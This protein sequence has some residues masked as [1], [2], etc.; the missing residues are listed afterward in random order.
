M[1]AFDHALQLGADM[2]GS[3]SHHRR[4]GGG[5]P[6][7][8]DG[9]PHHRRIGS[10]LRHDPGAGPG[11][12]RRTQLRP[13]REHSQRRRALR[14]SAPRRAYRRAQ[15]AA[16]GEAR[17]LPDSDAREVLR[18][19]PT[20]PTNIEIKGTADADVA[21]LTR[22][23]EALAE[24]LNRID[25]SEGII[26][27]SFNDAAIDHFRRRAPQIDLAPGIAGVA[28]FKPASVPPDLV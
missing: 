7:R 5:R 4:R 14:V 1:Y 17:R 13:R 24:L 25:R 11:S 22:N 23:A 10:G 2:I 28:R 3:T 21:S 18:T 9:R 27:V 16:R 20:I 12:R 15:A 26:V 19:Y 6:A 8:R